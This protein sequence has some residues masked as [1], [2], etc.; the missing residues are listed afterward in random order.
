M[1]NEGR[2]VHTEPVMPP[3]W[4]PLI[5]QEEAER[6]RIPAYPRPPIPPYLPTGPTVFWPDN[7]GA[8]SERSVGLGPDSGLGIYGIELLKRALARPDYRQVIQHYTQSISKVLEEDPRAKAAFDD[9]RT[10]L[11]LGASEG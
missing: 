4:P 11:G 8:T 5:V 1:L 10:E 6:Y 7:L 9:M 3:W 2:N